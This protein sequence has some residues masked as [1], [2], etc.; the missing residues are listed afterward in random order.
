MTLTTKLNRRSVLA[1]TG[2]SIAVLSA[3]N[4]A[5]AQARDI[6]IGYITA[7]SGARAEF[8]ES[9]PWMLE[10]VKKITDNGLS[11]GGNTYSVEFIVKDNQSN[12]NRSAAVG[13]E[14][15]QRGCFGCDGSQRGGQKHVL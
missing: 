8:G 15:I 6:R 1:G 10:Q 5:R 14:L 12:P 13:N 9:D 4:I 7:L 11:I 3:P 2:A